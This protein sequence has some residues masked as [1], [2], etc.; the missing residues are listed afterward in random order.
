MH[1]RSTGTLPDDQVP[2]LTIASMITDAGGRDGGN[3][4]M[5]FEGFPLEGAHVT[6]TSVLQPK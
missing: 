6:A 5:A 4:T 3:W 1:L 2:A